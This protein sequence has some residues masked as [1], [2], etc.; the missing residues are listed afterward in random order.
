MTQSDGRF[1]GLVGWETRA[2]SVSRLPTG[3]G[4]REVTALVV[5]AASLFSVITLGNLAGL[6]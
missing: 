3:F 4:S 1:R 2:N 5:I 6:W